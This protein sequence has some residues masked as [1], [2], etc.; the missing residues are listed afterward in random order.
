MITPVMH[1]VEFALAAYLVLV[2]PALALRR[3]LRKTIRPPPARVSRYVRAVTQIFSC[4]LVLAI[5]AWRLGWS[6][7]ALG[8]DFPLSLGGEIGLATAVTLIVVAVAL[9]TIEK[10]RSPGEKPAKDETIDASDELFPRT[11]LEFR[12][13]LLFSLAVGAGWE[14]LYRGFLLFVLAPLIGLV[15]AI[16]VAAL[17]YGLGHGYKTR[18]QLAGSIVSAFAFTVAFA[19]TGSLWWLMLLHIFMAMSGGWSTYR[20]LSANLPERTVSA[21]GPQA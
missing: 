9:V 2:L 12:W 6:H 8:L 19:V 15:S 11:P 14:L 7:N 13:F 17:V 4:L 16:V 20:P 10:R 3:S 5:V 21:A 1:I 18:G